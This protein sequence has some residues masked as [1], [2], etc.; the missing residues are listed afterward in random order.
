VRGVFE[1]IGYSPAVATLLALITTESP[2]TKVVLDDRTYWVAAGER[3]LPQGACTSP[4]LSNLVSRK[5]D[6]RLAGAATK[7]GWTYTR[8]ADDLTFSTPSET[9]LGLLF[10]R[11]RHIV[12]EEGFVVNEK[13]G[14]VQH[15]ARRQTVTG[16]VVNDAPGVPREEVRRIR[17]ILHR[18]KTTG[19]AAQNRDN[20]PDFDAYLRG[21]I[22]Y[23]AMVSPDRGAVL[24][25]AYEALRR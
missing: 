16:I 3:A 13:K 20:R 22:A 2:R 14:R 24:Q 25:R 10:A 18:A 12:R 23:I 11:I 8:Y 15:R 9:N 17:A 1:S 4:A 21:K 5:L 6:R 19:L 7:L